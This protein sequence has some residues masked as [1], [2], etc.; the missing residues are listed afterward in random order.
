M[1]GYAHV[2]RK[3]GKIIKSQNLFF[4]APVL[5]FSRIGHALRGNLYKAVVQRKR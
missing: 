1:M 4:V 2:S 3:E 5:L